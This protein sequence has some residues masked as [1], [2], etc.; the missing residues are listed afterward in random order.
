MP[1]ARHPLAEPEGLR[2]SPEFAAEGLLTL[3]LPFS[4]TRSDGARPRVRATA[5]PSP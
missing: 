4:L 3:F 5:R 1:R 2:L